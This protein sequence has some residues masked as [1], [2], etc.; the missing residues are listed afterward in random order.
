MKI[1]P[2]FCGLYFRDKQKLFISAV[3][4]PVHKQVPVLFQELVQY[5]LQSLFRQE[6]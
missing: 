3:R 1:K 6:R 4:Q 2:A 5:R